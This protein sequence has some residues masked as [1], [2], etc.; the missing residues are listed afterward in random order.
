MHGRELLR[1]GLI[2]RIGDGKKVDV[3]TDNWIPRDGLM[4]PL[5]H[6]PGREIS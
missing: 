2:W 6:Y 1:E 5:G 4:R 3:W